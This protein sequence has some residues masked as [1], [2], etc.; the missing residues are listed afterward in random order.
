MK[1]IYLSDRKCLYGNDVYVR[2]SKSS[3]HIFR[4]I[5]GTKENG[6]DHYVPVTGPLAAQ[7]NALWSK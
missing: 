5:F 6:N 7:L 1:F 3:G 4:C 2:D